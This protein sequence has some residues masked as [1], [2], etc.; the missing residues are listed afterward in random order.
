MLWLPLLAQMRNVRARGGRNP[1]VNGAMRIAQRGVS[2][3]LTTSPVIGS[4]D[5]WWGYQNTAANGFLQQQAPSFLAGFSH[6]LR[7][8]R[9][10]GGN[11]VGQ[12]TAASVIESL[13]CTRFQG[14]VCNLSFYGLAGPQFSAAAGRLGVNLI[15]GTGVD[16]GG[17]SMLA[18]GWTGTAVTLNSTAAL[19]GVWTRYTFPVLIP[20]AP[21][22]SAASSSTCPR[23][24]PEPTTASM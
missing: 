5:A 15:T 7:C 6:R 21:R 10:A 8:G 1:F 20:A 9:N 19:T 3:A 23:A 12:I 17:V 13:D 22:K 2:Q 24:S 4:L 16:Q 11:Q 14:K 18:G